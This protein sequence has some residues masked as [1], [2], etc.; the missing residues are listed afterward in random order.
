MLWIP[1]LFWVIKANA[2]LCFDAH[3]NM[4]VTHVT[5]LPRCC[6]EHQTYCRG[7]RLP[8]QATV[9]I[10]ADTDRSI[11]PSKQPRYR[12]NT[13][14]TRHCR[15]PNATP[16]SSTSCP[17]RFCLQRSVRRRRGLNGG[18]ERGVSRRRAGGVLIK[19]AAFDETGGVL[20]RRSADRV[21]DVRVY[22]THAGVARGG[23]PPSWDGWPGRCRSSFDSTGCNL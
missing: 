13:A 6:R 11:P 5:S 1:R 17:L 21:W 3:S 16:C 22:V 18:A 7:I 23:T 4:H 8:P 15:Y 12:G 10:P 2:P 9:P 19:C 14:V 20:F